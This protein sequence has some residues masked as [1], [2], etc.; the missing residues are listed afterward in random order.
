MI[1]AGTVVNFLLDVH[2]FQNENLPPFQYSLN[3]VFRDVYKDCLRFEIS[4]EQLATLTPEWGN[5]DLRCTECEGL[6]FSN[7]KKHRNK[8]VF[9]VFESESSLCLVSGGRYV[10]TLIID[11]NRGEYKRTNDNQKRLFQHV[12]NTDH[13][14]IKAH[15]ELISGQPYQK[16]DPAAEG[17]AM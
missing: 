7:F 1:D 3:A 16:Y 12:L 2:L 8:P 6:T 17:G 9:Y 5:Y 14:R 4:E 13:R 15:A 11:P 10:P